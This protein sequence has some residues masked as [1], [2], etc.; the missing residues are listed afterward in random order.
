MKF[1]YEGQ[2]IRTSKTHHYT[3]ACINRNKTDDG[4]F[5]VYGCSASRAGAEKPKREKLT[6]YEHVI[7]S[8]NR[9]LQAIEDGKKGYYTRKHEFISFKEYPW[10]S[11]REKAEAEKARAEAHYK[12]ISEN[13]IVVE[14]TEE[15]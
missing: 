4:K 14:I 9:A 11:T 12:A 1:Y 3:H 13:W 7:D 6:M 2:L 8:C 10:L 5:E 15:A